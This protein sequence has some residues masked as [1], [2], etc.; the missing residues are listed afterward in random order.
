MPINFS[1][2]VAA[3]QRIA[4]Q[5]AAPGP[6]TLAPKPEGGFEA[7]LRDAVGGAIE[8]LEAGERQ[9]LAAAAGTADL[10][11]VVMAVSKAELTLQT[12][13]TV[14]DRVIQAYQEVLRMPI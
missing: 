11:E 12:V 2:A 14:R 7:A 3:Y 13:V 4:H 6:E 5:G 10:N 8:T 9:S 1:D